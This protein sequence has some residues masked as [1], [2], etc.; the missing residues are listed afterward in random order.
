MPLIALLA[1]V[2]F[3]GARPL[4]EVE[5]GDEP[6]RPVAPAPRP[7]AAAAPAP[8]RPAAPAPAWMS[9]VSDACDLPLAK[10]C[11]GATC[12]AVAT[13]PD[14]DS[15]TG[16]LSIVAT[17][18][19]FVASTAARDLGVPARG[20]PCGLAVDGLEALAV[21]LRDGTEVWCVVDGDERAGR[22]LCEALAAPAIGD[23]AARFHDPALRR[24]RFSGRGG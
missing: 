17:S 4:R 1:V 21:E 13:M 2:P 7:I 10:A 12:V 23:A 6:P 5:G 3:W 18:P 24:L 16:W 14:L 19:R 9:T 8:S 20:M 15:I 22:A 11:D